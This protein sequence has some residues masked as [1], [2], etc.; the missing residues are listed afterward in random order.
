MG[1]KKI[2]ILCYL[3]PFLRGS[4]TAGKWHKKP[5]ETR[6]THYKGVNPMNTT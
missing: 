5:E 2:S 4:V 1:K 3:P 6:R